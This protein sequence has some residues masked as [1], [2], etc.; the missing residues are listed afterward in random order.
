[1]AL[2]QRCDRVAAAEG[3]FLGVSDKR[4]WAKSHPAPPSASNSLVSALVNLLLLFQ[5]MRSYLKRRNSRLNRCSCVSERRHGSESCIRM[6]PTAYMSN[7]SGE[8]F[9]H[10]VAPRASATGAA[11]EARS[12]AESSGNTYSSGAAYLGSKMVSSGLKFVPVRMSAHAP[13]SM[14]L[15]VRL[16]SSNKRFWGF[17]SRCTIPAECSTA[18]ASNSCLRVVWATMRCTAALCVRTI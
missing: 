18:S 16:S 8:C 5:R 10:E 14:S 3:R 6:I 2:N 12:G 4:S 17:T 1:M 13:K 9:T 11:C 15:K 7:L